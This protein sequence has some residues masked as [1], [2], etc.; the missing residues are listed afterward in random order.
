MQTSDP[1]IEEEDWTLFQHCVR[2]ISTCGRLLLDHTDFHHHFGSTLASQKFLDASGPAAEYPWST[3]NYLKFGDPERYGRLLELVSTDHD[4]SNPSQLLAESKRRFQELNQQ[5]QNLTFEVAF[6]QVKRQLISVTLVSES[7]GDGD[8][9][10]S[11]SEMPM[12]SVSPSERATHIGQYLMTLPQHLEPFAG[13]ESDQESEGRALDVALKAG[14][15]PFPPQPGESET[16]GLELDNMSDQWLGSVVRATEHTYVE[17]VSQITKLN[18]Q[19]ARQL[20]AD[21]DYLSNVI[22]S[23]GLCTS[24]ELL[25]LKDL[26]SAS[27]ASRDEFREV[28]AKAPAR[29]ANLIASMRS[30]SL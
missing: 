26:L 15:L 13:I 23:L 22:E 28:A 18:S 16:Q 7:T 19:M 20:V 17:A 24:K 8:T 3:Y 30:I 14:R 11:Q 25:Q 6:A 5:A 2:I 21:L 9:V 12:F 4:P 27:A 1:S 10:V 29:L